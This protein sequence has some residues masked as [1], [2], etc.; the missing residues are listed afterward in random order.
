MNG[1]DTSATAQL[2]ITVGVG[3][4]TAPP[5]HQPPRHVQEDILAEDL[6]PSTSALGPAGRWPLAEAVWMEMRL[7]TG[8]T[9]ARS[10]D[11]WGRELRPITVEVV[12]AATTER[13]ALVAPLPVM[14]M[15]TL[16]VEPV[17]VG[18][19]VQALLVGL[20]QE[21]FGDGGIESTLEQRLSHWMDLDAPRVIA[22][23]D[24]LLRTLDSDELA[25]DVLRWV[26]AV[27]HAQSWDRRRT[28]L[29]GCLASPSPRTRYVAAIGLA[30]MD[31]PASVP[32]LSEALRRETHDR[33][34]YH[35]G[36]VLNQLIQT[37][38]CRDSYG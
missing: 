5:A 20:S 31:D 19:E 11:F 34:R 23:L 7:P 37:Q 12:V 17:D 24:G 16:E 9:P 33:L 32:I 1:V 21:R 10:V 35:L 13:G 28:L 14:S 27:D 25:G 38:R 8:S 22:T 30:K 6:A 3:S 15:S 29:E 26:A 4:G 36:R 18:S 2:E